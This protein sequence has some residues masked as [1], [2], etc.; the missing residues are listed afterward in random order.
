LPDRP[1][2]LSFS[3]CGLPEVAER[4]RERGV[5]KV[6]V[7]GIETH[8]CVQQTALDL[9]AHGFRVYV[10]ADAVGSR[11]ESDRDLALQRMARAGAVLT[12]AEAALFEWTEVAG[13]PEFKQISKLVLSPEED[14]LRS[15]AC[16]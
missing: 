4:F 9:L 12:S 5:Q 11:R 10:A 13:T 2:K 8:V 3:C 1:E 15:P 16:D 6:L 14:L 7:A